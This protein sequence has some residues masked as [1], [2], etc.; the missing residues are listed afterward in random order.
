[1]RLQ[2]SDI[3]I[4]NFKCFDGEPQAL[5]FGHRPVGLH[6]VR[7]INEAR[8]ALGSNGAGKTSLWDAMCWC[9]YG[10]TPD[11]LRNPDI[12]PWSGAKRTRVTLDLSCD[13]KPFVVVR[14]ARPNSLTVND[15]DVGQERDPLPP[16]VECGQLA[17]DGQK[18][19]GV[20]GVIRRGDGEVLDL[21][22]H[23][24]AERAHEAAVERR[25]VVDHRRPEPLGQRLDTCG[26]LYIRDRDVDVIV[27][28]QRR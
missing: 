5:D 16:M 12:K 20:A 6:F 18:G 19:V 11:G 14:T 22:D 17:D 10:R 3:E 24:V 4:E 15:E 27:V 8:P 25:Q 26:V 2:F 28:D 1:M 23:L 21:T 13:D 9:L 7:G